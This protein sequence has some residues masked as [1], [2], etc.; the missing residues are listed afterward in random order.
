ML[1]TELPPPS[2]DTPDA[3]AARDQGAMA[4]VA[5][6]HPEDAFEARLA[7]RIVA[8]DAHAGDGLRLA[9]LAVN[10]PSEMRRCRA[11]AASMARQSDA[12]LRSLLRMQT[13]REKQEAAMHPAAMERAGYW[14]RDTSV[15]EPMPSPE[16]AAVPQSADAQ[17]ADA[18]AADAE[19]VAAQADIDT[20][21]KFYAVIYPDRAARIREAGGLPARRL[22]ASG[23]QSRLWKKRN[24]S[25]T[26]T[27]FEE[28]R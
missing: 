27:P 7:V 22:L 20:E 13:T 12:A 11:Q 9:G 8:M 6:L 24:S 21:A 18:Q 19:P 5:A 17:S 25:A 3:R 15:P 28:R 1:C 14:F 23:P 10:D 16:P 2:E 26:W 4:A